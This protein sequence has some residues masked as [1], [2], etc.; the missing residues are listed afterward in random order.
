MQK[1]RVFFT[2]ILVGVALGLNAQVNTGGNIGVNIV[3]NILQIDIAP[4]INYSPLDDVLFGLS[5]FILY[6]K[7]LETLMK[8]YVY[9]VRMY[10]EYTIIQNFFVHL[11]YEYSRAWTNEG[12]G[13][14]IHSAPIGGGFEQEISQGVVAYGMILYDVLYS[15]E[16]S[17]RQNPVVR[18]GVR[19]SF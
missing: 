15:S 5:P 14:A 9:G 2:F 3:D 19:Y 17:I 1:L 8:L 7:D 4:E 13:A 16:T 11:E 10:G 12:F 18:A 6:S